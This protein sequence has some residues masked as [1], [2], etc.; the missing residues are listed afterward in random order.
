MGADEKMISKFNKNSAGLSLGI[1]FLLIHLIWF[2]A[3]I[4]GFGEELLSQIVATHF[5]QLT[6]QVGEFNLGDAIFALIRAF[7]AGYLIGWLFAFVYNKI[8]GK[9]I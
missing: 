2:G 8:D 7:V 6:I 3:V 5:I 1:I 9:K 4:F